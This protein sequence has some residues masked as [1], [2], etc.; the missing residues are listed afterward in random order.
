MFPV[1]NPSN[2]HLLTCPCRGRHIQR[3]QF[4]SFHYRVYLWSIASHMLPLYHDIERKTC[5]SA[6]H[7]NARCLRLLVCSRMKTVG[8]VNIV[9][10]YLVQAEILSLYWERKRQFIRRT[11]YPSKTRET[12]NSSAPLDVLVHRGWMIKNCPLFFCRGNKP[13][14][15]IFAALYWRCRLFVMQ[16]CTYL[17]PSTQAY[18]GD[19]N[20]AY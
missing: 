8:K 4:R 3:V 16:R 10:W 15:N 14:K 19:S 7:W 12:C 1:L 2:E 20:A 13:I 5:H 17:L 18:F 6:Q 11:V 9:I